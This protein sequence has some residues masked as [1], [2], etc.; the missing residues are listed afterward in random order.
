MLLLFSGSKKPS[1]TVRH[2]ISVMW[3]PMKTHGRKSSKLEV[4]FVLGAAIMC[5]L[6]FL[7]LHTLRFSKAA[8]ICIHIFIIRNEVPGRS[9][10]PGALAPWQDGL[11]GWPA[12]PWP[13]KPQSLLNWWHLHEGSAVGFMPGVHSAAYMLTVQRVSGASHYT[14]GWVSSLLRLGAVKE[15]LPGKAPFLFP[16]F[17]CLLPNDILHHIAAL[18]HCHFPNPWQL[19]HISSARWLLQ[20]AINTEVWKSQNHPLENPFSPWNHHTWAPQKIQSQELISFF[21]SSLFW[22]MPLLFWEIEAKITLKR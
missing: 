7:L 9:I 19:S 6:N 20:T 11:N 5:D 8:W 14:P 10:S 4:V 2:D 22:L 16:P 13:L 12:L 18:Q 3:N 17:Q 21:F 15:F 1:V